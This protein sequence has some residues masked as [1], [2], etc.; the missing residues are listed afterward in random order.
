MVD[1][2]LRTSSFLHSRVN[3]INN[4]LRLSTYLFRLAIA[5]SELG[6]HG[7]RSPPFRD[8]LGVER[9]RSRNIPP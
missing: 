5:D 3:I 2:F 7:V 1:R 6:A 4:D 8:P 9:V